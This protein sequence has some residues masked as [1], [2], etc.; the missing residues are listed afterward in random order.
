[1]VM[2]DHR[3]ELSGWG[4]YPR[5]RANVRALDGWPDA[6]VNGPRIARGA[7]RSYGDASFL[8]DGTVLD[9]R[10]RDRFLEFDASAG[11]IRAEAGVTLGE[12]LAVI[13]PAGWFLP[14]TPG[15][16]FATL[17]GSVAADVHGKNHHVSGNL[18]NFVESLTVLLADGSEAVCSATQDAPLFWA[19]CG[20]MGLTGLIKEVTLRLKRIGTSLIRVRTDCCRDLDAVMQLLSGNASAFHY[21][22]AWIDC[23]ARGRNLGRSVV[24]R[25]DHARVDDLPRAMRENPI[26]PCRPKRTRVPCDLP[27]FTLNPLTVR[28][29]N[30]LYYW[31]RPEGERLVHYDPF[32]Y[33]L[34]AVLG[35]N[36]IYG[37]RGFLQY[38]CVLPHAISREGLVF[39]LE[40][41][42]RTRNASFLAVLKTM[43]AESGPL[44][45][46]L[47]GFTLALDIPMHGPALLAL[48]DTLDEKVA[49]L[50]GRVYLAKDARMNARW[51]PT[52]YPRLPEWLAVKRRVDPGGVFASDLSRRLRLAS[53][54]IG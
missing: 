52:M 21:S 12:V 38:Q 44:G 51:M 29:F 34:D 5:T 3:E 50:G 18:S 22:V 24:M 46:P 39:L 28:V 7:G 49:S 37:R 30:S 10:P 15:T 54:Q 4:R 42:A 26:A 47:P 16:K 19:T 20:G 27:G 43:G 33:P 36:R 23:L 40:A 14:V 25:G 41:F 6:E 45:F 13:V 2:K 8:S 31:S 17:G 1:M 53:P 35:W 32:F 48:L 9:A 11:R